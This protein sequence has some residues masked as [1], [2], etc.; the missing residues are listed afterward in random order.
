MKRGNLIVLSGPSGVGK[1]TVLRRLLKDYK[2]IEYSISATTRPGRKGEIHGKDYFFLSEEEF[3]QMVDNNQF[4]EW[5]KVHNNY[6]GTPRE[7]VEKTLQDGRDIILEIDIQGARKVRETYPE[8]VYVFLLPPSFSEL[9]K[10]LNKRGT[11]DEKTKELRLKNAREE[12]KEL[13]NYDY[14]I[15]NEDLEEAVEQLKAIIVAERC[16]VKK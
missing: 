15:I 14:Q 6:Y 1:G 10:R 11:E 5:A 8:A 2:D 12:L 7:Y 4:I 3:F 16:R 13:V 9:E